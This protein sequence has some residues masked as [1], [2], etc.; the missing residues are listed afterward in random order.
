MVKIPKWYHIGSET[1]LYNSTNVM[2]IDNIKTLSL[3]DIF[4]SIKIDM[5]DVI[6]PATNK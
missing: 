3:T 1:L 2:L 5:K 4:S 6:T